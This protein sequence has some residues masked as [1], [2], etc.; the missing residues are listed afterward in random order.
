LTSNDLDQ[1]PP[2]VQS[3]LQILIENDVPYELRIFDTPARQASQAAD[4]LG[5]PLGAIVKSL[6]FQKQASGEL[7][8]VLVSG[9]NRA[10]T[11]ILNQVVDEEVQPAKPKTVLDL[12]GYPV[13][14]V[15]PIGVIGADMVVMD[16]DLLQYEHVWAS[17]GSDNIL[18]KVNS[19]NLLII[20]NGL[21]ETLKLA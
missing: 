9:K 2:G 1:Y 20:T 12:T 3:V 5:C 21:V 8:L 18:M 13:G 15:P 6:V 4:L 19:Q 10:D 16:A 7:L 14:A 11:K 17:A